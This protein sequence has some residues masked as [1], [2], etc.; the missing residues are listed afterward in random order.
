MWGAEKHGQKSSPSFYWSLPLPA[1]RRGMVS[2]VG[3]WW[4]GW[5]W[6]VG[7][8]GVMGTTSTHVGASSI[9]FQLL[10]LPAP[11]APTFVDGTLD[12]VASSMLGEARAA[13]AVQH[14]P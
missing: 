4:V 6:W 3:V 1:V 8:V 14:S 12:P 5:G 9:S 2:R 11:F 13:F 10:A 7:L